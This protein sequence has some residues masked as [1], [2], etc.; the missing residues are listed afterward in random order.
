MDTIHIITRCTRLNN[1]SNIKESIFSTDK[2]I[3]KWHIIFDTSCIK[4]ISSDILSNLFSNDTL[5]YFFKGEPGDMGHSLI[6]NVIDVIESG[7]IY[8]IDDDNKIHEEF[9]EIIYGSMRFNLDNGLEKRGFIFNQIVNGKD[10]SGLDVRK[11]SPENTKV[12]HIDMA[13]FLLRRDL[14][15]DNR[16]PS[17]LYVADG[18][19]I[20]KIFNENKLDFVFI[21]KDIS[22]YNFFSVSK[23]CHSIPRILIVGTN[24]NIELKS[25][26]ICD[27]ESTELNV[28]C[29]ENDISLDSKLQ[30]FNPDAVITIGNEWENFSKLSQQSYDLRKRWLHFEKFIPEIGE[31]G[32]QCSNNYILSQGY[33]DGNPL[34]S[35]FTPIYNTGDKLWRTYESLQN[36]SYVNWEWVM[37]NDSSDGGKT[38]NIA[39]DICKNDYR[40]KVH[41]FRE[42]SGGIV[43]ESKYRAA[44]LSNGK[45]LME[46]DHDDYLLPD[47]GRLMIEAFKMYPDAKFVYSDCAEITEDHVS[48]TYGDSFSFGY[49]SY[50]EEKWR[51]IVYQVANTSNINPKT[52]RHIVGVPNHFR[53]WD[54]IFYH[55]IGGHNRKLTI[56]DDYEL[57]VRTF[58]KTKM[59]KIPKLLYLQ[60]YHD[61]NTQN[62]T[63]SD[64]QRRVRSIMNYYNEAIHNRFIELGITDWAYDI[65]PSYPLLTDSRF[66]KDECYVNYIMN[67]DNSYEYNERSITSLPILV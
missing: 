35:F 48:L 40:C 56:A 16:I 57:I 3:I 26:Y 11:A 27:Y 19:F 51:D 42:K 12:Q 4:D 28:L 49:G 52:I 31:A 23:K 65:N 2:F 43:G 45:Y 33:D 44:A 55:S 6:N 24:S 17:G 29:I 15:G 5:F 18:I 62:A 1:I 20:E 53:A 36:Q 7:Y 21:D 47:A 64:I 32:Y 34:I 63:R 14:I 22:Y 9:Y 39:E 66:G 25:S 30:K 67:V 13:Q 37:V 41:D 54:R 60:F 38:Q 10:F 46:L 61:N 50:R 58:L 59:V 8:I